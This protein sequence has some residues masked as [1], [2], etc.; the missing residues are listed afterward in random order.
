MDKIRSW[1]H[2]NWYNELTVIV[3]FIIVIIFMGISIFSYHTQAVESGNTIIRLFEFGKSDYE[4]RMQFY[5]SLITLAVTAFAVFGIVFTILAALN[6]AKMRDDLNKL[7]SRDKDIG[8]M[9]LFIKK[10]QVMQHIQNSRNYRQ[11]R[12][13]RPALEE[14]ESAEKIGVYKYKV[15][16]EKGEVYGEQYAV[17][18]EEYTKDSSNYTEEYYS[19]KVKNYLNR[20]EEYYEKAIKELKEINQDRVDDEIIWDTANCLN[21]FASIKGMRWELE[22]S[23]GNNTDNKNKLLRQAEALYKEAIELKDNI[24]EFYFNLMTLR[25]NQNKIKDAYENFYNAIF[26][27]KKTEMPKYNVKDRGAFEK[28]FKPLFE[29]KKYEELQGTLEEWYSRINA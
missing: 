26:Y 2:K 24:P 12:L 7:H 23:A 11:D 3:T 16:I 20:A 1:F 13:N 22:T 10:I 27:D 5:V 25:L 18:K 9:E 14:L 15:Y 6:T 19:E 28:L 21:S 29:L 4:N 17:L 8:E